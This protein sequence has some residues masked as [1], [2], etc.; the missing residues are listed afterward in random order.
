MSTRI[1][2]LGGTF[3]PIHNGH[4]AIAEEARVALALDQVLLVPAG[5]QPL[6]T[7]Q[8]AASASHRMT[9]VHRACATNPAFQP[10]P[11]EIERPGLSY[12]AT[13]LE[14]L[15]RADQQ[16]FFIVGGDALRDMHRWHRAADLPRLAQIVAVQRPGTS[17]A[18]DEA[19]QRLPALRERLLVLEGPRLDISSSEVRRRVASNRPIRYLVPDS[20]AEYIVQHALYRD[21]L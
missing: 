1:G 13:T 5:Q 14:T 12:T 11:I 17:D 18:I 21:I 10:S 4:L 20:V 16:V 9:M 19:I 7:R 8:Q 2:V 3:D 15:A 6:K